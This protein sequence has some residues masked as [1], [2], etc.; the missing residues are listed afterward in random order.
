MSE[1]PL[2]SALLERLAQ[3][4]APEA[5]FAITENGAGLGALIGESTK[6]DLARQA[7]FS[8]FEVLPIADNFMA[9]YC[10]RA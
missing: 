9:F 4:S 1:K 8:S 7:G 6:R 10:L 5:T 3:R 2:D